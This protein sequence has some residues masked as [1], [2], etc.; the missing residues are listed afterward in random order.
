MGCQSN[1][2]FQIKT[3]LVKIEIDVTFWFED[4][5]SFINKL[6]QTIFKMMKDG[7]HLKKH[8]F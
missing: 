7:E 6:I 8:E 3:L 2:Y 4:E 5:L 1:K